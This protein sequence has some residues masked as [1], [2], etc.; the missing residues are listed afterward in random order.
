[1][2]RPLWQECDR[3]VAQE[4]WTGGRGLSRAQV[5]QQEADRADQARGSKRQI[6]QIKI[7][8]RLA[9]KKQIDAETASS[10]DAVSE[11]Q[12]QGPDCEA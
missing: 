12:L 7:E 1:M 3:R 8:S 5:C 10:R 4:T 9:S 6:E 11:M 2:R